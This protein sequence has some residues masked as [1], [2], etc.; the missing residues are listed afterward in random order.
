MNISYPLS[1]SYLSVKSRFE[2]VTVKAKS[3]TFF[4]TNMFSRQN[5][6]QCLALN[7]AKTFNRRALTSYRK[8]RQVALMKKSSSTFI[9]FFNIS[10]VWNLKA[11]KYRLYSKSRNFILN[12][13]FGEEGETWVK[14]NTAK[15][16][17]FCKQYLHLVF[18]NWKTLQ[19]MS[20]LASLRTTLFS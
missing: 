8:S 16:H 13:F 3:N 12:Q 4:D 14:Q 11:H 5:K 19:P 7:V 18:I 20:A 9:I 17:W 2:M 1:S 15:A 6:T 10:L